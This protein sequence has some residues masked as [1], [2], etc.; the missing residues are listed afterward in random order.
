MRTLQDRTSQYTLVIS[1]SLNNIAC[2][3]SDCPTHSDFFMIFPTIITKD[4]SGW[5][6]VFRDYS[7]DLVSKECILFEVIV[8]DAVN[9]VKSHAHFMQI[10]GG[11]VETI[12]LLRFKTFGNMDYAMVFKQ[13]HFMGGIKNAHLMPVI[14]R[15]MTP[16]AWENIPNHH[17]GIMI[18]PLITF[19]MVKKQQTG[20]C[21]GPP[22]G[23]PR[24]K[25]FIG[26]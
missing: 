13:S 15:L 11:I 12:F 20:P 4:K 18:K 7:G 1:N 19:S 10:C 25:A 8:K 14:R 21:I 17:R 6:D 9:C 26:L 22:R 2:I 24:F 3:K 5:F 16:T 23:Y